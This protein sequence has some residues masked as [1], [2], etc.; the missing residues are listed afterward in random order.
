MNP[1]MAVRWA[2]LWLGVLVLGPVVWLL[3][4]RGVMSDGVTQASAALGRGGVVP[5]LLRG[6]VAMALACAFGHAVVRLS[7]VRWGMFTAGLGLLWGAWGGASMETML[8]AA[9]ANAGGALMTLAAETLALG[10]IGCAVAW[11]LSVRAPGCDRSADPANSPRADDLA[12][13]VGFG[14]LAA[15]VVAWQVARTAMPG[16]GAAVG[17][18]SGGI[19]A[20]LAGVVTGRVSLPG[21]VG[22]VSLAGAASMA[23][24]SLGVGADGWIDTT[25]ELGG[26]APMTRVS[27][28]AWAAGAVAGAPMG[29]SWAKSL[30]PRQ[31]A[32][33]ASPA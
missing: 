18:L 12:L 20:L 10:A 21:V 16:Q 19:G 2:C 7:S 6:L 14:A 8:R 9:G 4:S 1:M 32:Q 23:V 5:G 17:L 25:A 31:G 29:M 26:L 13:G 27:P 24:A 3:V 11:W 30:A 15:A 33:A 22:G 28:W